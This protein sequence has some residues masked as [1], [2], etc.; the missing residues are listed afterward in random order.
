MQYSIEDVGSIGIIHKNRYV[1]LRI[2][3][4]NERDQDL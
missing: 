4:G 2:K 1:Q 3:I